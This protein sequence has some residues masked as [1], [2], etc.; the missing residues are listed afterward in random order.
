MKEILIGT[1]ISGISYQKRANFSLLFFQKNFLVSND[2]E[3]KVFI[4]FFYEF[5][6]FAEPTL[7]SETWHDKSL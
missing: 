1:T 4:F 2:G 7:Q 3:G 5:S 6:D